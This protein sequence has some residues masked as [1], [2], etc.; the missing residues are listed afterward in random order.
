MRSVYYIMRDVN[1]G[2]F[3]RNCHVRSANFM[4]ICIYIH[5][6]RGLYYGSYLIKHVWISGIRILVLLMG[7]AF[8]GYV[9]PWGT[10]SY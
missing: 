7:V 6:G 2:W 1:G 8:L 10:M 5:I 4:F 9:L 3:I